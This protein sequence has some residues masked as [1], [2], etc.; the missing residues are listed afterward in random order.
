M[1]M[2]SCQEQD[3]GMHYESVSGLELQKYLVPYHPAAALLN[4]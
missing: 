4:A 1:H 2:T 3:L